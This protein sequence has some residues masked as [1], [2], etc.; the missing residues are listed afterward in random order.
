MSDSLFDISNPKKREQMLLVLAAVLFAV[1]AVPFLYYYFVGDINKLMANRDRLSGEVDKLE[2]TLQEGNDTKA[3]LTKLANRSLPTDDLI[4]RADYRDWLVDLAKNQAKLDVT[5]VSIDS[6]TFFPT[7]KKVHYKTYTFTLRA[8]GTLRQLSQFLARFQET[9]FLHLIRRVTPRPPGPMS[10]N[11][12][13]LD[14]TINIEA[15]IIPQAKGVSTLNPVPKPDALSADEMKKRVDTIVERAFFTAY[16]PPTPTPPPIVNTPTAVAERPL[17][18]FNNTRYCFVQSI[19]V[20][21]DGIPRVWIEVRTLGQQYKLA[22][23]ESFTVDGLKCTIIDIDL[24]RDRVSIEV[25]TGRNKSQYTYRPNRS[26][27]EYE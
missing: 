24:E 17:P 2:K 5:G 14:L 11:S 1:V 9:D 15:L 19:N 13:E 12:D 4:V 3:R 8:K 21:I 20:G 6:V 7:Q 26:F 27:V 22:K 23:G 25:D 18:S 16:R 10:R